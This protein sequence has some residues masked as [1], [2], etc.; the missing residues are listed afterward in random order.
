MSETDKQRLAKWNAWA[1]TLCS[2][3]LPAGPCM[4]ALG[5]DPPCDASGSHMPVEQKDA[6][7]LDDVKPETFFEK[8]GSGCMWMCMGIGK[9]LDER[10]YHFIPALFI[11][12]LPPIVREI[13]LVVF[14]LDRLVQEDRE[15]KRTQHECKACGKCGFVE[16]HPRGGIYR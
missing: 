14:F 9:W 5:H 6:A 16:C 2:W 11:L 15:K 4:L 7:K 1:K 10:W 8:V 12:V 3:R 13:L